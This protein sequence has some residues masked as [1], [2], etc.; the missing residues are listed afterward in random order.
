M[1]PEEMDF[2]LRIAFVVLLVA[3][4]GSRGYYVKKSPWASRTREQRRE[5]L[6][7]EGVA[8]AMILLT[9]WVLYLVWA[10][11]IVFAPSFIWWSFF[12]LDPMF[13][14]LGIVGAVVAIVLIAWTH[15]T[16]G[17][18]F[19]AT[20]AT[21]RSQV[22][23]TT[24]PYSRVRHPLYSAHALFNLSIVL[25]TVNWFYLVLLILGVPYTYKRIAKEEET[26][27]ER[28]GQEYVEY[29]KRTGRL[30]PRLRKTTDS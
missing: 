20:V 16:L 10:G 29:M 24:G 14:F 4:L 30:F 18:S 23:V 28:F 11:L 25:V 13:R 12:Q 21:H 15:R 5:D 7:R 22:L 19:T 9:M 8:T 27:I 3:F 2:A 17:D 26:L 1:T 6:K